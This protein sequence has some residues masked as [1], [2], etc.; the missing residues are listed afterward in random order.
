MSIN[1]YAFSESKVLTG[2]S[3]KVLWA[4]AAPIVVYHS[5]DVEAV[6]M[7]PTESNACASLDFLMKRLLPQYRRRDALR[8]TGDRSSMS[9]VARRSE[10]T[11]IRHG[12]NES[13]RAQEGFEPGV[14]SHIWERSV[15]VY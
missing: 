11:T 7:S 15:I 5:S 6:V 8:E 10:N 14:L 4:G 12:R 1:L 3:V 9:C 2:R 13:L